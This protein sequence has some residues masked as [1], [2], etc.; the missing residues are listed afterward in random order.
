MYQHK[1][2][3]RFSP[4]LCVLALHDHYC[5]W[6]TPRSG[7]TSTS[8]SIIY[9]YIERKHWLWSTVT[10]CKQLY[11]E[12]LT[13]FYKHLRKIGDS[14]GYSRHYSSNRSK[15]KLHIFLGFNQ[16]SVKDCIVNM[17]YRWSRKYR[18]HT[19]FFF[20]I[21]GQTAR[22]KI[23][24]HCKGERFGTLAGDKIKMVIHVL[25]AAFRLS[26]VILAQRNE[27][28]PLDW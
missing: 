16:N 9:Y 24:L 10:H 4:N 13:L 12:M 19:V 11:R 23:G 26:H 14:D 7:A 17:T 2:S 3:D 28:W 18:A 6:T 1:E 22:K 20:A 15:C 21:Y 27:T 5:V 25:P 8:N